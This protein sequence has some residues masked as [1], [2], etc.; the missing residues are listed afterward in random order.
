MCRGQRGGTRWVLGLQPRAP[1]GP[2][3]T[4]RAWKGAGRGESKVPQSSCVMNCC[5][6]GLQIMR[7]VQAQVHAH[8]C[9]LYV[10][11]VLKHEVA[12]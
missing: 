3:E 10:H 1:Q 12:F 11:S 7:V 4:G 8:I 5:P 2:A 6:A 9:H